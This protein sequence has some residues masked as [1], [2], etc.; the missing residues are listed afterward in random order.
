MEISFYNISQFVLIGTAVGF[1]GGFLGVGLSMVIIPLLYYWA[2]PSMLI[3]PEVIVHLS[4]G[5]SL[6]IIIPTSLSAS[7]AHAQ[8]GNIKWRVVLLLAIPGIL[9]SLLGS[10]L[11]AHI[12][13]EL[14]RI[15]FGSL[16]IILSAQMF[17]PKK[18]TGTPGDDVPPRSFPALMIGLVVG[19]FSGFFGLGGGVL[20]IP[21]MV[22][23]LRIPIYRAMGISLAFVFFAAL[24][25]TAGYILNGLGKPN[26]PPFAWGYVY[27]PAWV[28][29][30]VPSLFLAKW[31]ANVASKTGPLRIHRV[32]ALLLMLVG[33][34]MLF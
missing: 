23:F 24:M 11:T 13:G 17:I 4:F 22:R 3:A 6:A 33:F 31:G 7:W 30:G 1:L 14:L 19:I 28:L 12:K 2:F 5:T 9:G 10:T 27:T 8:A 16:L 20:A 21:L 25:G 15:L 18:E 34:R 32:F 29:A 26:L